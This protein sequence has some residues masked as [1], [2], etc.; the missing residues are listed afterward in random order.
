[1]QY[2]SLHAYRA[3]NRE[4][5][6][7]NM[8]SI[9]QICEGRNRSIRFYRG[10][11]FCLVMDLM[12]GINARIFKQLLSNIMVSLGEGDVLCLVTG[13]KYHISFNLWFC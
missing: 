1:M 10:E 7:W 13:L 4:G 2:E 11:A 9:I 5:I 8:F 3:L 12:V 6:I